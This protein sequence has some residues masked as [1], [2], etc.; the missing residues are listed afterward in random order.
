M[1]VLH[2]KRSSLL[3]PLDS[4][5]GITLLLRIHYTKVVSNWEECASCN[6]CDWC[7]KEWCWCNEKIIFGCPC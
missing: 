4:L 1:E 3:V 5:L 2:V 7:Y 6:P